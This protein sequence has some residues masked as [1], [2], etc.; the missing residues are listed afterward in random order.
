MERIQVTAKARAIS[1]KGHLKELRSQGF[2]PCV[3]YGKNTDAAA[4]TVGSKDISAIINSP[5]GANT[6]VDLIVDGKKETVII[7]EL[8]RDILLQDRFVHVDFLQISLKDKLEVQVP[9]VLTGEAPGVKEGGIV[10]QSLREIALKCLPS[11]IPDQVELDIS[12]LGVGETLTVA[13]I[14]VPASSE[15]ISDTEEAVVT[16]VASRGAADSEEADAS[17]EDTA[18]EE[19]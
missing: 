15:I 2:V 13:D 9:V 19:E 12:S 11:E 5:A 1:S 6:L 10:Q 17:V 8:L 16:I 7:K 14:K 18:K 3:V 4:V